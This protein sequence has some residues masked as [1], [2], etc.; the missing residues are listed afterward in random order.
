GWLSMVAMRVE[1]DAA[2]QAS[3]SHRLDL[4]ELAKSR[5]D[6]ILATWKAAVANLR[7]LLP[8]EQAYSEALDAEMARL[9]GEDAVNRAHAAAAAFEAISMPYYATYF[10]WREAEALLAE[11]RVPV[12][13]ELLRRAR[14]DT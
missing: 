13:T 3:A 5:A 2:V 1:A 12:A 9:T 7:T 6:V 10:R 11:G 14:G 4:I 8:L